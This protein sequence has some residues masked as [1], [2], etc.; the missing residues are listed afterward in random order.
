MD[1]LTQGLLGAAVVQTGIKRNE[2]KLATAVGFFA[3]VAADFD[4]LIRSAEDSLLTIE[5]HRHFTHS[6]FFIPIG[7]L[8]AT[9]LCWLLLRHKLSFPTLYWYCLLG[10]LFSGLLDACTSYG[11]H[12]LWPL[13][14]ERIAWHLISIVDPLFTLVLILGIVFS[15]RRNSSQAAVTALLFCGLYLSV[16][17]LQLQRAEQHMQLLAENRGHTVE[18][19]IVK[20]T[21]GNLLLWRSVY[22]ADNRYYIDAIRAGVQ[23]ITTYEGETIAALKSI[24]DIDGIE[25]GSVQ[26]H[27]ILRF[28]HFSDDFV[29]IDPDNPDVLGDVRYSIFPTSVKP[30]WGIMLDRGNPL[31][32][33]SYR[34]FRQHDLESRQQ[35][36]NMLLGRKVTL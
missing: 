9:S 22:L 8:I 19:Y 16:G 18:R 15:L 13:T 6:I 3:G 12:L 2:R 4:M 35:F 7:A 23:E 10:Y 14:D 11:T 32:H 5:Y 26:Y 1:L 31:H 25:E 28:K 20:P 33:A 17:F 29:I 30:L 34:F 36:L 24:A 27:D 21:I